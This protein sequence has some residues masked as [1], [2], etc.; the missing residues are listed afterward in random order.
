MLTCGALGR[1]PTSTEPNQIHHP[2]GVEDRP[3]KERLA[4]ARFLLQLG[5]TAGILILSF[6]VVDL[7]YVNDDVRVLAVSE[8]SVN[9]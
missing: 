8:D 1:K 5:A 9:P 6:H 3:D 7:A 2:R 4:Q